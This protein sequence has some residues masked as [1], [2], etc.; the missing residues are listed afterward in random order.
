VP[1]ILPDPGFGSLLYRALVVATNSFAK[2]QYFLVDF[3]EVQ[4]RDEQPL[5]EPASEACVLAEV[6]NDGLSRGRHHELHRPTRNEELALA[7]PT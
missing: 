5:P 1:R 6:L 2:A 3:V 4:S 7:M